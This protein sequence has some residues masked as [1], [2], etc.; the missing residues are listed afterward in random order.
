MSEEI[1][2]TGSGVEASA[3][4]ANEPVTENAPATPQI[5]EVQESQIDLDLQE[6]VAE[7]DDIPAPVL[8]QDEDKPKAYRLYRGRQCEII[9][10]TKNSL[11]NA[12]YDLILSPRTVTDRKTGIAQQVF[13]GIKMRRPGTGDSPPPV[14]VEIETEIES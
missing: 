9:R 1:L 2:Q 12:I 10:T 14:E 8:T 7:I 3:P 4:V 5:A 13:L 6:K 11:T